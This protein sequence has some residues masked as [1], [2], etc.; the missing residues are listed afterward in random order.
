MMNWRVRSEERMDPT[1]EQSF[2]SY[3]SPATLRSK[4][5]V[6][7]GLPSEE[8]PYSSVLYYGRTTSNERLL[9]RGLVTVTQLS[10]SY[11]VCESTELVVLVLYV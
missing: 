2:S 6:S 11:S 5:A 10:A 9:W 1:P 4:P 3:T 7:A 8:G